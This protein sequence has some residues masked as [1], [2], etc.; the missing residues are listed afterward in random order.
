MKNLT[1]PFVSNQLLMNTS[2]S[3]TWLELI[4]TNRH[5]AWILTHIRPRIWATKIFSGAILITLYNITF[6]MDVSLNLKFKCEKLKIY[7]S[8][9]TS[10]FLHWWHCGNCSPEILIFGT[11]RTLQQFWWAFCS[12]VVWSSL[13]CHCGC[14]FH[15]L[16]IHQ[17]PLEM[18]CTRK[19]TRGLG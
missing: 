2:S 8:K 17:Y 12:S 14:F 13:K 6:T 11:A 19:C 1:W 4:K 15:P 18:G 10:P 16:H 7:Q 3:I 5:F 9:K